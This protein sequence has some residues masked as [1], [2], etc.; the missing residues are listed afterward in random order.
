MSV[1]HLTDLEM[2]ELKAILTKEEYAR[3]KGVLGAL[4][5]RHENLEPEEQALLDGLFEASPSLPKAYNLREKLTR[6]FDKK[7]SKKS[8]RRAIRRWMA[9]GQ[10]KRPELF[11]QL[12]H[13]LGKPNGHHHQLLHQPFIERLGRRIEQ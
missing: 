3:L 10:R 13:P 5:K 8:G 6:L 2:K 4:Q 1:N 11:R 7:H 9:R 12:P